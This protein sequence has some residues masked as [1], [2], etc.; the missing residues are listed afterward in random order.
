[1]PGTT[2]DLPALARRLASRSVGA[3][4]NVQADIQTLL[5]YG[6][7]NLGEGD[8]QVV[9]LEAQAG[10]GKRIDI[11]VGFTVIE[12]KRDLRQAKVREQA[13]SQLA[14]YV[15][16][17]TATLGQRYVGV[18]TD[19]AEWH[20][21]HLDGHELGEVSSFE[22]ATTNPD[23]EGLTVWLEGALA[24]VEAIKPTPREIERRLGARSS[25]HAL[26]YADLEALYSGHRDDP[27]VKLK[28]ELWARLLTT[29]FGTS[30]QDDE[31][32]F[33]DHTLLVITAEIIAHAVLKLDPELLP[34]ASVLS[35]QRFQQAGIT[36]VVEEDFFDW[37]VEVP[38]GEQYV[39]TL[40][41]RLV[42]FDWEDVE[43]DVM[44][45][46]Y[47]SIINTDW[48][49]RLGEYYTPDWLAE[50]MVEEIVD[51]PL[52]QRV[53]DPAC[54]S[55]T[56]LF[57]AVRRYLRAAAEADLSLKDALVGATQRVFGVD[58]HPVAVTL[59]RLTYLLAIGRERLIDPE[60]PNL[61]IPVYLG[62]SVQWRTPELNL[63]TQEGLTIAVDSD[64]LWAS[65]L[66]FPD[67]LLADAG[68]FDRFVE[69]LADRAAAR[70]SGA[71]VPS[72]A[73][74]FT[75]FGIHPD[76][77]AAIEET[78][79]TMCELHDANR[80]HIWSY[81]IRNLARP[82][83]LSREGNRVDRLVGNPPWLAYRFMTME[84]QAS[85]RQMSEERGLWAGAS[86]A[87]HQDLSALFL[88]RAVELYLKPG[89]RFSFVMP[90]AALTRRQF[91]GFRTGRYE[92]SS[93]EV[94]LEFTTPWDLH[95]I[96]PNL[97]RVPPSVI[98]GTRAK[99]PV[100]LTD[101]AEHWAGR[102]P[103]PNVGW[104]VA[105][106][107]ITRSEAADI[108]VAKDAPNS[109]YHSRFSQG[110]SLV[111]RMLILVEDAPGSPIGVA[112]G[113]TAVRS[114]RS[115]NE[116]LPWKTLSALGGNVESEFVRSVHL[117]ATILP[118]RPLEPLKA[119]IPWEQ[120]KMLD[121][122][123]P[124]LDL[125]PGLALWWRQANAVW[126]AN[127]GA[128]KLSLVEQINFR[129]KLALQLP[130]PP[131]R[132]VYTKGGQYLAA[133]RLDDPR[134]VIDHTLYWAAVGSVEEGRYLATILNAPAL[135]KL[136]APLQ[137]RGEHNPR[138][139]DKLVW[140]LPIPIYDPAKKAHLELVALAEQAE[141]VAAATDL[142]AGNAFQA[143]R[144]LIREDLEKAA[145]AKAADALVTALLDD[146]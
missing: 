63:W 78:F 97:F 37:V 100:P 23:V 106:E 143:Q 32:L 118:F 83:W 55:G 16:G 45:V 103:G 140:R 98:S 114:A 62:D 133:A 102:I 17:R 122:D 3:E 129:N 145:I 61:H 137:P 81:Y 112:A 54:G 21:Y 53:L 117:G 50:R 127:K 56:F 69:E 76:D 27:T 6:G 13:E 57:Q 51:D 30:F 73:P 36:G 26:D 144:R 7:L 126:D 20:L 18:L 142:S 60:R 74:I 96:K 19:G 85:F 39:R 107:K 34:P 113:T 99:K 8:L 124:R 4:A 135:T 109:L 29:A 10:G 146:G 2:V 110:A 86:V 108:G 128:S 35:G 14:G 33:L 139:F 15:K 67:R 111:P 47:E 43:H 71:P 95:A 52:E 92:I 40:A 123:D 49:H 116:K 104:Q 59:A 88:V 44:K 65:N 22:L 87:T 120:G 94:A 12:V 25:A 70:S 68:Q 79:K 41:R 138:H 134:I 130:A 121:A 64:T 125:Y 91:A 82:T 93:G 38:G 46:L 24:T 80:D 77:R 5:L 84:M 136:L 11:E 31:S 42:R 58:V 28:R 66:H 119:V 131:H 132:V 75:R 105:D 89:G 48:R 1:M 141:E 101:Q 115:A 72:L 90:L 9:E